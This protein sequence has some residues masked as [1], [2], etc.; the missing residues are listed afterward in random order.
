M[1]PLLDVAFDLDGVLADMMPPLAD[2][3]EKMF[4]VSVDHSHP[5][6]S[7]RTVPQVSRMAINEAVRVTCRQYKLME[8]VNGASRLLGDLYER[9]KEPIMIV[10]A[11]STDLADF[12]HRLIRRLFRVPYVLVSTGDST[13]KWRYLRRYRFFIEDRYK[14]AVDLAQRGHRVFLLDQ[15]WN[16]RSLRQKNLPIVRIQRLQQLNGY[17][18]Q[19]LVDDGYQLQ[20]D[21]VA[22]GGL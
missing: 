4:G 16:R 22:S 8:P 3:I 13:Q 10:T 18:D 15:P 14:T 9:S 11:R 12:T 6:Y 17:F 19:L 20:R 2:N 1:R 21:V 7:I 5:Y